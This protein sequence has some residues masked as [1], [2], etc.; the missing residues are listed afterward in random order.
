MSICT[1][2]PAWPLL[3]LSV[4][5]I[6]IYA[7]T[8][9][10][11]FRSNRQDFTDVH[12]NLTSIEACL[13]DV[14]N[15]RIEIFFCSTNI[16]RMLPINNTDTDWHV[17]ILQHLFLQC[18]PASACNNLEA[19]FSGRSPFRKRRQHR[20]PSRQIP[21]MTIIRIEAEIVER[22]NLLEES[23]WSLRMWQIRILM[24]WPSVG[25]VEGRR[26]IL[27]PVKIWWSQIGQP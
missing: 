20:L 3:W 17:L 23:L 27:G 19:E 24:Q 11:S 9:T 18:Q 21:V 25:L 8:C 1:I 7:T 26:P 10:Y 5:C 6:G 22:A 4:Y 14:N 16:I 12:G 2:T 13:R 15:L